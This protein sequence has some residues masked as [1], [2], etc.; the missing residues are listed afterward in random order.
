MIV[1]DG[2]IETF[3]ARSLVNSTIRR[4]L[5]DKQFLE[6]RTAWRAI[7][8]RHHAPISFRTI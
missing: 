8:D 1:T 7:A 6:V 5:E 3:R 4:F 2:I